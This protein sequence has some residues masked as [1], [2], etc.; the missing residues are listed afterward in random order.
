MVPWARPQGRGGA[1]GAGQNA[2]PPCCVI[3]SGGGGADGGSAVAELAWQTE[4]AAV[5]AARA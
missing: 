3:L 4:A 1:E 5:V 2:P